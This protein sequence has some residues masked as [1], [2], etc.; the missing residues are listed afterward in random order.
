ES[1]QRSCDRRG[2]KRKPPH[3]RTAVTVIIQK[4]RLL[5]IPIILEITVVSVILLRT[6]FPPLGDGSM[7]PLCHL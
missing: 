4:R 1:I 6:S 7:S 2:R 5:A 3:R